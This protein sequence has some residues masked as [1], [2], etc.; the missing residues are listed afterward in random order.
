M[1]EE[2]YLTYIQY[3]QLSFK[4]VC[5]LFSFFLFLR[6]SAGLMLLMHFFDMSDIYVHSYKRLPFC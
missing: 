2:K 5:L 1:L 4:R 6:D 3:R